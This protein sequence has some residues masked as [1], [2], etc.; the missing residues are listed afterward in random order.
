MYFEESAV[1]SLF[2]IAANWQTTISLIGF[3]I[4][5]Y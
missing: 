5:E 2:P 3:C 1:D 4:L